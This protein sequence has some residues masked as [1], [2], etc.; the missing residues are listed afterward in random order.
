MDTRRGLQVREATLIDSESIAILCAQVAEEKKGTEIVVLHVGKVVP[1]T[2]YFV[3]VT[4]RNRRQIDA[5]AEEMRLRLKALEVRPQRQEG[6]GT[7]RW[8]LIDFGAVVVHLFDEPTRRYYD[9]DG[10]WADCESLCYRDSTGAE[11]SNA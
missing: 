5:I 9:L 3:L 4:A 1:I 2:D 10:L 6:R 11:A 7:G 8:E